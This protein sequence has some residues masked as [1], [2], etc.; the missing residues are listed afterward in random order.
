MLLLLFGVRFGFPRQ[1]GT[2]ILGPS[3]KDCL[4]PAFLTQCGPLHSTRKEQPLTPPWAVI[5]RPCPL[6]PAR[7]SPGP[8]QMDQLGVL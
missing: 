5:R 6:P 4:G 8:F 1:H 3:L 7:C 2:H